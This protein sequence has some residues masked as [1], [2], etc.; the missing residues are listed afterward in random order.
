MMSDNTP[1]EPIFLKSDVR[2][3]K[4]KALKIR[5][6]TLINSKGKSEKEFYQDLG[7]S[8]QVWY[9]LS[10]GIWIPTV[11]HKVRISQALGTDSSVIWRVQQ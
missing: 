6:Q 4:D 10:W 7:Y 2:R 5:L 3:S 1:I 9:A 11:E 8:K